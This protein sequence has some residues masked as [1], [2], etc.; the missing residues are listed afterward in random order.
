MKIR[1]IVVEDAILTKLEGSKRN[2]V[3]AELVDALVA[4][5]AVPAKL[6][7]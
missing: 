3:L 5:K 4:A 6:L 1:D 2:E 7:S